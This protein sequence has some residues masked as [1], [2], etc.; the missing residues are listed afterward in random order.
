MFVHVR[1]HHL[2]KPLLPD[3]ASRVM[4]PLAREVN[5]EV[6][7]NPGLSGNGSCRL[8]TPNGIVLAGTDAIYSQNLLS[9]THQLSSNSYLSKQKGLY[10]C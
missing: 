5:R 8:A 9:S 7:P 10:T 4:G 2:T 6:G 3:V 1:T